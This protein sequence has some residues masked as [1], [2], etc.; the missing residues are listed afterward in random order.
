MTSPPDKQVESNAET[1]LTS[2]DDDELDPRVQ[3]RLI[4]I[5]FVRCF[6]IFI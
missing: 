3:V 5:A 6:T 1:N 2:E 4:E